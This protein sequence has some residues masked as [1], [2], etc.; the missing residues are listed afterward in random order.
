MF[1]LHY[2]PCKRKSD[3]LASMNI[4]NMMSKNSVGLCAKHVFKYVC[5]SHK[6]EILQ[7]T[8]RSKTESE[9]ERA[10]ENL[11]QEI[12]QVT[13]RKQTKRGGEEELIRKETL[14]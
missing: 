14:E 10:G 2:L 4:V 9:R 13:N 12:F 3:C 7:V 11:A 5:C 1:S 8:A 6:Q